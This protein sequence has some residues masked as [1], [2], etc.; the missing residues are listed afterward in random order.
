MDGISLVI[1]QKQNSQQRAR[2]RFISIHLVASEGISD[3]LLSI[4][5]SDYL[6]RSVRRI[7]SQPTPIS[8]RIQV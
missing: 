7:Q 8:S 3:P 1:G 4:V 5:S 6:S 2:T